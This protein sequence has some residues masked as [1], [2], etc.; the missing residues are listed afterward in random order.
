M[1]TLKHALETSV[2]ILM[3]REILDLLL[4]IS[5]IVLRCIPD[6]ANSRLNNGF[7]SY[8]LD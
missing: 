4:F 1:T 5:M 6:I 3:L 8:E 7:I 2:Q